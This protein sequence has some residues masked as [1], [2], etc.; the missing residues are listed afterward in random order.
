M[1]PHMAS[2]TTLLSLPPVYARLK[3]PAAHVYV[4]NG[5]IT[6]VHIASETINI[7]ECVPETIESLETLQYLG[8]HQNAALEAFGAFAHKCEFAE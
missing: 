4:D 6:I 3:F 1:C 8:L 5:W 7:R 2:V